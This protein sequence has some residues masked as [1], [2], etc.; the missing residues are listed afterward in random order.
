MIAVVAVGA[1][2]VMTDVVATDGVT[3]LVVETVIVVT[4]VATRDGGIV[5]RESKGLPVS[6]PKGGVSCASSATE[7][8][9]LLI[10]HAKRYFSRSATKYPI[11]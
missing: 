6:K 1:G 10:G 5:T 2:I 3:D 8:P 4:I 9:L 11:F 7:A